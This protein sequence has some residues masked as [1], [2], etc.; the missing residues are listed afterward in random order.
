VYFARRLF[1]RMQVEGRIGNPDQ[2][3][4]EDVRAFVTMTLSLL[5]M[6]LNG[7]VTV[8][9]FS[10]VLWSISR[11]L[12]VV[13]VA[14]AAVG[15]GLT[16]LFGRPLVRLNY[17]QSDREANFR[18]ELIHVR[19]NA[20]PIALLGR[21]RHLEARLLQRLG[22][23]VENSKRI[24]AV[25]RNV[26]FFVT[27]Y[28]YMVQIIPALIVAPLFIRGK[29]EFGVIAQSGMAFTQILG[30]FSL[31]VTQFQAISAYA[32]VLA[33][34]S[35]LAEAG[36]QSA[37]AGTAALQVVPGDRLAYEH[38]TL[39]TPRDGRILIRD[40]SITIA[41]GARVLVR[42]GDEGAQD[43]LFEAT[44]GTWDAG[45]GR[46]VRP[47]A[48]GVRLLP[49]R[50]YLAPGT[51]RQMLAADHADPDE[52]ILAALRAVGV[53]AV[54]ARVGGL[55]VE[56]DWHDVLSLSEQQLLSVAHV[57]VAGARLAILD[58]V[59]T[60]LEAGQVAHVLYVLAEHGVGYVVLGDGEHALDEYDAV[61]ELE[62]DGAW[63]WTVPPSGPATDGAGGTGVA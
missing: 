26:G 22:A 27:G 21:E 7:V 50:P 30:A 34:L 51:L 37:A 6:F 25:N 62:A 47:D 4:A 31:I 44:G 52:R 45:E 3:I 54:V 14:Y 2:R 24:I 13:G 17:D 56:R 36:E 12:F 29:V 53:E 15:S 18:S 10:G 28:N 55:D 20:G 33:R 35:V 1:H 5:L 42:G 32:A 23:L 16:V 61:L 60:A 8:I 19:Q 49:E 63:T 38:V 40:L 58:R 11:M 41:A 48:E 39:R 46:I 43:A 59:G 57:L 9:A